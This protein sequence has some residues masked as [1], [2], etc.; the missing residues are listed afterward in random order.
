[1]I[2]SGVQV[3]VITIMVIMGKT[4][5]LVFLFFFLLAWVIGFLVSF[6]LMHRWSKG[7]IATLDA[8]LESPENF[9][10]RFV[11]GSDA[12]TPWAA[13][14]W[15]QPSLDRDV[16]VCAG[17]GRRCGSGEFDGPRGDRHR[18]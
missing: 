6:L 9:D 3:V 2:I 18:G 13:S 11:Q 15:Y 17:D 4:G 8:I 12:L 7:H 10:R 1:M 16:E 14:R 5:S